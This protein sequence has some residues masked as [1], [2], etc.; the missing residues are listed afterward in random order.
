MWEEEAGRS[1]GRAEGGRQ[2]KGVEGTLV[3][4]GEGG[5]GQVPQVPKRGRAGASGEA[6]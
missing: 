1:G 6:Y 5:G 4:R 3:S 2:E